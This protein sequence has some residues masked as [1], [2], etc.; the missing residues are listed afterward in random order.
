MKILRG[1][2]KI[3]NRSI[4]GTLGG[5]SMLSDFIAKA[6]SNKHL[7]LFMMPLHMAKGRMLVALAMSPQPLHIV[8]QRR[9][10]RRVVAAAGQELLFPVPVVQK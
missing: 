8:Q 5:R 3:R 9:G 1:K 7:G 4:A 6:F 2:R 10:P